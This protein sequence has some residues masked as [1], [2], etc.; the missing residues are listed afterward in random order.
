MQ[1]SLILNPC[2]TM[3]TLPAHQVQPKLK[4]L[5]GIRNILA[6]GSGKGGVGKSTVAVNLA[7]SVAAMGARVGILDA[8]IYGPSQPQLLGL[9]GRKPKVEGKIFK[10]L[11]A[12]GLKAMSIG[13]LI[14]AQAPTIWRGPMVSGALQQ[15][16]NQTHWGEL[17]LLVVDLPPGTGDIQLTL[18]QKIPVTGAVVVTTP[19]DL[20]LLDAR[21]AIGLFEKLG[22]TIFGV[23]ENMSQH[24]CE[25]CGHASAIFGDLGGLRLA[26]QYQVPFLGDLPL[27]RRIREQADQGCPTVVADPHAFLA[28]T[29]QSIAKKILWEL[30]KKPRDLQVPVKVVLQDDEQAKI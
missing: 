17:D 13:F 19:Q 30:A 27:D 26:E 5:P 3:L 7:L 24:L 29:Y 9:Q 18:A 23:V 11:E 28:Q 4:P 21:K 2:S 15:L 14:D 22:I 20:A 8:D 10:P 25:S 12:Y 6:V 1:P 16:L